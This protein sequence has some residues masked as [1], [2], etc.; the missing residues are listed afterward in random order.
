[1]S[2]VDQKGG[3]FLFTSGTATLIGA[4]SYQMTDPSNNPLAIINWGRWNGGFLVIDHGTA[5]N[6][7]GSFHYMYSPQVTTPAQWQNLQS[8]N[9]TINYT[10]IPGI[11]AVTDQNG[12][13]GSINSLSLSVNFS[14]TGTV[15]INNLN[16]STPGLTWAVSGSMPLSNFLGGG[17]IPGA[18]PST[19]PLS[20]TCTG[21]ACG[22]TG[23]A[24]GNIN[25]L[26]VGAG[27]Q[28]AITSFSLTGLNN[29]GN[30]VGDMHGVSALKCT[31]GC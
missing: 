20:G 22:S 21:G 9:S 29:S 27:A 19:P 10:N 17:A 25:G 28:G 2:D 3:S 1:M 24:T 5:K 26:F 8:I 12:Q 18:V 31:S 16:A 7:I 23:S 15:N 14:G 11:G 13:P 4:G 30:V 6:S